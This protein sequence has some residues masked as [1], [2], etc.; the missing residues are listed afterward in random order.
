MTTSFLLALIFALIVSNA[1]SFSM[2]AP[3]PPVIGIP[4]SKSPMFEYLKFDGKPKFDVLKKTKEYINTQGKGNINE[5]LYAEDYVLRGPVIGPINRADL[6]K[7]Q[8]GLG[9]VAAFPDIK[10][11]TFGYTIDPENPYRCFY[12]QRWRGTNSADLDNYGTILPATGIEMETPVS[13]FCVVYNPEGKI[14]YE[15]V[16]AVVDRLEGNTQGKAAVFGL[17]HTAGLKLNANP[18]DRIF[19]LIQRLGHLAG[20][21]GRSWS[22][23]NDIPKWW[24]SKSRG[25]D[26][27]E[28]W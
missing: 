16:G 8:K 19:S 7:S 12:F 23:E 10:I 14:V 27:T 18:G 24:I 15:Q 3:S 13:V 17:L 4:K 20:N 6:A 26:A 5:E 11:E 9:I 22:R 21:L 2:Q 1:S 28:Q 25:A